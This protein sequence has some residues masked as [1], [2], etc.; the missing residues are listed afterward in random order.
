MANTSNKVREFQ[1]KL[2]L[3]S[4]QEPDKAFYSLYDK[5]CRFDILWDAFHLCK[6]NK[7][8]AGVDGVR[9]EDLNSIESSGQL[10]KTLRAELVNGTYK[11]LPVKRVQIP[12]DKNHYEI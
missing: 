4:K 10:I 3:R 1:R 12:K 2:Y 7:G 9:F 11:P 5:I 6:A 8:A